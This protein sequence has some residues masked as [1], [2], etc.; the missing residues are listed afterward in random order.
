ME[1]KIEMEMD[2]ETLKNGDGEEEILKNSALGQTWSLA[3]IPAHLRRLTA[4]GPAPKPGESRLV[5]TLMQGPNF[6]FIEYRGGKR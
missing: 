2:E 3:Y 5:A 4:G 6:S 1:T